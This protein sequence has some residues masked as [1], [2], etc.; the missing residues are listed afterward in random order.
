MTD[1][2]AIIK[3]IRADLRLAMD[4]VVSSSMREKGMDYK[5]NFG[6]NIPKI[7]LI[8]RNYTAGKDLAETLWRTDV[9]ELKIL[10]TLLYPVD[11]FTPE[12]AE[13]WA[14][15]I[16]NQEIREQICM[17]LLQTLSFA[18]TLVNEWVFS[19]DEQLRTTGYWLFARVAITR[20]D[21][22][23]KIN[24]EEMVNKAIEDVSSASVFLYQAALSALKFAGRGS[25]ALAGE[26]LDRLSDYRN[27]PD[28]KQQEIFDALRFEFNYG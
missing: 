22:V 8:S 27:S 25:K 28:P 6:V 15:E 5:M 18:G 7:R 20:S 24:T 1:K 14:R 10:A 16:P 4:G 17:N 26:I 13:K 2:D 23:R 12:T 19:S 21:A 9:R 3:Q 11:E